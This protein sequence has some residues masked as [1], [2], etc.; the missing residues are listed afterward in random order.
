MPNN[1]PPGYIQPT[2][3][4]PNSIPNQSGTGSALPP[5]GH[6]RDEELKLRTDQLDEQAETQAPGVEMIDPN[7]I[8]PIPEIQRNF[9]PSSGELEISAAQPGWAYLWV[10]NGE[11]SRHITRKRA[12]GWE[13]V[14]GNDPEAIEHKAVGTYRQVGDVIL[15]RIPQADFDRIRAH[16]RKKAEDRQ[17]SVGAELIEKGRK[18][19]VNVHVDGISGDPRILDAVAKRA[20]AGN[21]ASD[22]LD[23]QIRDGRVAGMP[24]GR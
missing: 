8:R 1:L 14:Q 13:V 15:M 20:Q 17:E 9:D 7:K 22:M 2:G 3:A 18:H 21:I 5:A 23:Q 10:Y 12:M 11:H 16:E 6:V 24:A 19:G 4:Q